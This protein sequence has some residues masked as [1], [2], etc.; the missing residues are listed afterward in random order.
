[1]MNIIIHRHSEIDTGNIL[2][3]CIF[4]ERSI[5]LSPLDTTTS[6]RVATALRTGKLNWSPAKGVYGSISAK[7]LSDGCPDS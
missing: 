4:I 1:M 3:Y 5:K 6:A 7:W 2:C